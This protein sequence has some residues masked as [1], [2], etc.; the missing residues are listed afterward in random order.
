MTNEQIREAQRAASA[1]RQAVPLALG[2]AR[3]LLLDDNF[4][5]H[6]DST[7]VEIQAGQ[8]RTLVEEVD[9]LQAALRRAND[10]LRDEQREGQRAASD[11]RAEGYAEGR[12]RGGY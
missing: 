12:E 6:E 7:T 4:N 10:D 3:A 2:T 8:L 1:H 11:A 5:D 9:R